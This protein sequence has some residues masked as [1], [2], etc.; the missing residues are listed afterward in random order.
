MK[1][2]TRRDLLDLLIAAQMGLSHHHT[3]DDII[4]RLA[5]ALLEQEE[6]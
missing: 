4:I 5:T 2:E 1:P 3:L 6:E